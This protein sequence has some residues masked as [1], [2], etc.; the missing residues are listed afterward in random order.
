MSHCVCVGGGSYQ[1][2]RRMLFSTNLLVLEA[3]LTCPKSAVR[4]GVCRYIAENEINSLSAALKPAMIAAENIMKSVWAIANKMKS[5]IVKSDFIII[6]SRFDSFVARLVLSKECAKHITS[7]ESAAAFAVKE[8]L[9]K[10]S[11]G[12]SVVNPWA[13]HLEEQPA[14]IEESDILQSV[15]EY[16][17]DGS[18][19][20]INKIEL[21]AKGYIEGASVKRDGDLF[22]IE[23]IEEN[24]TILLRPIASDGSKQKI[25]KI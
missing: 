9:E 3:Q 5:H 7:V 4:G 10:S 16:K 15:W 24:G 12:V 18:I 17:E 1:G 6:M 19:A 23:K 13:D 25:D 21:V 22:L 11:E 14:A 2:I 20:A 8:L